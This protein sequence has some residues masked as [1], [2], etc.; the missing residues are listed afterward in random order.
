MAAFALCWQ[1][2]F[3]WVFSD[4]GIRQWES[5]SGSALLLTGLIVM[6]LSYGTVGNQQGTSTP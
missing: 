5:L 6:M 4:P 2:V 3:F 1:Q